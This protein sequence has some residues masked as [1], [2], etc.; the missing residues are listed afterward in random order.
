M[1]KSWC[2]W[3]RP[4]QGRMMSHLMLLA[5]RARSLRR[6]P[7]VYG[8]PSALTRLTLCWIRPAR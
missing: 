4:N 2:S 7:P 8:M 3:M 6:L 5:V 1:R